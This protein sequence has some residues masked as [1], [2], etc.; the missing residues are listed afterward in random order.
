M[1]TVYVVEYLV[2]Q[3]LLPLVLIWDL[4]EKGYFIGTPRTERPQHF[5]VNKPSYQ[6]RN[7]EVVWKRGVKVA[8][9]VNKHILIQKK[10]PEM[11]EISC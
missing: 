4:T 6:P 2:M 11:A 9:R 1:L 3:V 10:Q 8:A 5:F 7:R